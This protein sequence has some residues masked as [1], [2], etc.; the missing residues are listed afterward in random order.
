MLR[1]DPIIVLSCITYAAPS[2]KESSL[3]PGLNGI[4]SACAWLLHLL[5]AQTPLQIQGV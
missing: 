2:T 4:H 1:P 3:R 5:K